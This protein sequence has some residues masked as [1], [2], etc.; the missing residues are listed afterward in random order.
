MM[1]S[2]YVGATGMK[3][4]SDG[5]S[6]VSNNIANSSTVGYKQQD[7]LFSDLM[8]TSQGTTGSSWGTNG[9]TSYVSLG[10]VGTGVQIDSITTS[11]AQGSFTTTNSITDMAISGSGFFQ[12][13]DADGNTFYTRSGNFSFDSSGYLGLPTGEILNGYPVNED[14][15]LGALTL[16]QLDPNIPMAAQATSE[17]SLSFNLGDISNFSDSTTDPYFS[18]LQA[19]D[20]TQTPSLSGTQASY[21]QSITVY[22][23]DGVSQE[24]VIYF[25]GT[26][27]SDSNQVIEFLVAGDVDGTSSPLMSG[28]L[29][30]NAA[31]ELT[32]M[33]AFTPTGDSTE[34]LDLSTWTAASLSNGLPQ[35]MYNGQSISLD[36]GLTTQSGWASTPAS[37]ADVGT[38]S[39]LL[40]SM[41]STATSSSTITTAYSGSNTT[42]STAQNGYA[43]GSLTNMSVNSDGTVVGIYSNG[44]T[45]DL[46]SIPIANFTNEDGLLREGS[47]LFSYT[48]DAGTMTLGTAG[49]DNYGTIEAMALESSNVDLAEEM[50]NMIITQRGFQSNSK[51]VTTADEMLKKAMELKR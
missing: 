41:G 40:A 44:Q 10:Q 42:T 48:A 22:D 19:F 32:D 49:T 9:G 34:T 35:L 38:N 51:V 4:L 2:L 45:Q 31:G 36:L 23:A 12:V 25:D 16:V 33:S 1:G 15:T 7:I 30:F 26:D 20:S 46:F 27:S 50:V 21:Q 43:Q 17:V 28:T 29:T 37:A 3:S 47:N 6:V 11:F 5:M 39:S 13:S 24:L 8:Y 18:L 14:G